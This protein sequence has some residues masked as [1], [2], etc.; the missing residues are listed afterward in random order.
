MSRPVGIFW[1]WTQSGSTRRGRCVPALV[2]SLFS[3]RSAWRSFRALK[4]LHAYHPGLA[5][6][7]EPK[8]NLVRLSSAVRAPPEFRERQPDR[9]CTSIFCARLVAQYWEKRLAEVCEVEQDI[10]VGHKLLRKIPGWCAAPD[11]GCRDAPASATASS[12][13]VCDCE[14]H[15]R[16][17]GGQEAATDPRRWT[18]ARSPFVCEP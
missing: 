7:V 12:P 5:Q 2:P 13:V 8:A 6:G 15:R 1:V 4:K 10:A 11:E 18:D 3:L 16:V 17:E 9:R 14:Q